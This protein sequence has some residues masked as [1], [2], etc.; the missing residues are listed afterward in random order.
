VRVVGQLDVLAEERAHLLEDVL[1]PLPLKF[2]K[3]EGVKLRFDF[4]SSQRSR[5]AGLPGAR[6]GTQEPGRRARST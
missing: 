1:N 6:R 3:Q 2:V 4:T 5:C